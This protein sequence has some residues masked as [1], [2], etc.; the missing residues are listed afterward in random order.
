MDGERRVIDVLQIIAG[1]TRKYAGLTQIAREA[2]VDDGW[3]DLSVYEGR[4]R[5]DI[6]WLALLTLLGRH[7]RSKKVTQRRVERVGFSWENPLPVQVDGE[8]IAESP[9]EV[10]VVAGALWVMTPRGLRSPLFSRNPGE[11]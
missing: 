9:A 8:A 7:G 5:W 3:L 4:G 11:A 1:N 6:I 2:V 10:R